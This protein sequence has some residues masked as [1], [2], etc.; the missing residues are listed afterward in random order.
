M[1][2][3][4][5]LIICLII[6]ICYKILT[7]VLEK[8]VEQ[9]RKYLYKTIDETIDKIIFLTGGYCANTNILF[10]VLCQI[11]DLNKKS[12]PK[13]K[14]AEMF[15]FSTSIEAVALYAVSNKLPFLSLPLDKEDSI[16]YLKLI[17]DRLKEVN[18][19]PC[20]NYLRLELIENLSSNVKTTQK[21]ISRN[22]SYSII[23]DNEITGN[24]SENVK[25]DANNTLNTLHELIGLT[26]VKNEVTTLLNTIKINKMREEK[27]L[28]Q[29]SMSMHLVFSGN[30]GTGKTTVARLLGKIY[31]D[32]GILTKG[33]LI[34]TDR[35][36][37]VAEYIG[38][39]AI[40]TK[41]VIDKAKGGILF[42][43]E[44]Y[45][46]TPLNGNNDFGQEAVD[47][48][49][50]EMEDNRDN[51]I[52]IV[53]GYPNLMNMFL[54]SNPGLQSRFNTFITFEDYKP[55][56]LLKIF[57]LLCKKNN[58]S[59]HSDAIDYLQKKFEEMYNKRDE[60]F[61]N[62]RTI[63]NIFEKGIKR[64][65]NRLVVSKNP[66]DEELQILTIDDL[67]EI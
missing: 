16:R 49:L 39:T 42:I 28:K 45:T 66:T 12:L 67:L 40:K 4:I 24:E 44:A 3:V 59:I 46:L 30:P 48:L 25:N 63:R 64:Q 14:K 26:R 6:F 43:D 31:R 41:S 8:K 15:S 18:V 5:V 13:S 32:L 1:V 58:Y 50:K 65:A 51:L 37:M 38:Q 54:Q 36:G 35:A 11:M 20:S 27:G 47:T 23:N 29:S 56:E 62:G 34:E 22:N 17:T 53:A 33:H 7:A 61:A 10:E 55:S 19:E 57:H 9:I 52:V 21:K 60:T 2:I